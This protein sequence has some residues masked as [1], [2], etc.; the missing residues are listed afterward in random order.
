[1]LT[2]AGRTE[3]SM[4]PI[5]INISEVVYRELERKTCQLWQT[6]DKYGSQKDVPFSSSIGHHCKLLSKHHPSHLEV[7]GKGSHEFSTTGRKFEESPAHRKLREACGISYLILYMYTKYTSDFFQTIVKWC[8]KPSVE[9]RRSISISQRSGEC[10]SSF[11]ISI[12]IKSTDTTDRANE[13]SGSLHKK[14]IVD[15]YVGSLRLTK[16]VFLYRPYV[17]E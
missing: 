11:L 5:Y 15:I 16:R 13:I 6:R 7:N 3:K 9:R 10:G 12:E 4:L 14:Q 2:A 8:R 17:F 1:M